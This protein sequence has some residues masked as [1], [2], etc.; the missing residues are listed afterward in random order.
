LLARNCLTHSD[1]EGDAHWVYR[2]AGNSQ[3]ALFDVVR[4]YGKRISE[5]HLRQSQGGVWTE[6][7]GPGD[8]D[9]RALAEMLR[10]ASVR[11]HIVLEQAIETG[12]P[13]TMTPLEAFKES[14]RATRR[15]FTGT[16][17]V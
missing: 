5:L 4:L 8:I 9:Y 3:V 1:T 10:Q 15:L 11:P 14:T 13:N 16:G 7:F 2:G 12:S 17:A 6:A